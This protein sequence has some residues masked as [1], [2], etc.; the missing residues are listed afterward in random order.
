MKKG[1]GE[2]F[3]F[4][5]CSIWGS[6]CREQREQTFYS[7]V[8]LNCFEDEFEGIFGWTDSFFE[9]DEFLSG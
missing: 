9:N 7:S 1:M 2:I 6:I 5:F 8:Y 4:D 3:V